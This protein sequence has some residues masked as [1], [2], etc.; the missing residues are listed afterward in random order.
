MAVLEMEPKYKRL[1]PQV[2]ARIRAARKAKGMT[3]KE[4][5]LAIGT[6]PQTIQRLETGGMTM[7]LE[8]LEAMAKAL[9]IEPW[10][11]FVD[12]NDGGPDGVTGAYA[13][14]IEDATKDFARTIEQARLDMNAKVAAELALLGRK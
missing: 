9:E 11:L 10:K 13:D 1:A 8:W 5:G 2:G 3:L 7:S 4:F 12:A 6:T 14:I